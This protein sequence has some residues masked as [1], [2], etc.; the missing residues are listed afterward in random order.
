MIIVK[1]LHKFRNKND[2][3]IGYK[4]QDKNGNTLDVKSEYLKQAIRNNQINVLNLT[5]TSDNKLIDKEYKSQKVQKVQK[6][7]NNTLK[8][9][10]AKISV[11]GTPFTSPCG[12]T[13]Y[14]LEKS[15]TTIIVIP[16]DVKK[17]YL[18]TS[19]YNVLKLI[20]GSGL[21]ATKHM[22]MSCKAQSIDLSSFDTSKVTNMSRMFLECK[23]QSLDLSSFDTSKVKSMYQMF[24]GCQA[25]SIN[26]SS[27]DTSKV[28]NM[29]RM[30]HWC[31][32]KSLDLSSFDTSNVT[33]MGLMFY[34]CEAQS[35]DLSSFDA[36]YVLD[37][38]HMFKKCKAQIKTNDSK[39]KCQLQYDRW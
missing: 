18:P 15:D 21:R 11:L 24:A 5:L 39:L 10:I 34:G 26:L 27:F 7:Q 3:I 17:L 33:K 36:S 8:N 22:F 35:I 23:T 2:Q 37:I 4:I 14:I 28:I 25:E 1:C 31:E 19:E 32:A 9:I 29:E 30:F 12:H 6:V 13:Y 20:G 16:N 38:S